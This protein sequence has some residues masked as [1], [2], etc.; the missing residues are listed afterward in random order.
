VGADAHDAVIDDAGLRR[1]VQES[2]SR[3]RPLGCPRRKVIAGKVE[4]KCKER[5]QGLA[6]EVKDRVV[7]GE[8]VL[9]KARQFARAEGE[10]VGPEVAAD[11]PL[12]VR[13]CRD[14]RPRLLE[15]K[16]KGFVPEGREIGPNQSS[17]DRLVEERREVAQ[18]SAVLRAGQGRI[19]NRVVS[20]FRQRLGS[21]GRRPHSTF[22]DIKPM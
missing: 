15:A 16:V 1:V 17:G 14:E 22:S 4:R 8:G 10:L 5:E 19:R 11:E 9:S 12:G 13:L 7:V 21:G 3:A 6:T 18:V 20:R 2:R